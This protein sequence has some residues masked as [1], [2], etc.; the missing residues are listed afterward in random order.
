MRV[1][2]PGPRRDWRALAWAREAGVV[3]RVVKRREQGVVRGRKRRRT[4][5]VRTRRRGMVKGGI[6]EG[7]RGKSLEREELGEGRA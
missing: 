3:R 6:G 4:H 1:V 7:W 5:I 2:A